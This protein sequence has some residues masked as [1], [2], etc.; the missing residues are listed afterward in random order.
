MIRRNQFLTTVMVLSATSAARDLLRS[1]KPVD[2]KV[3]KL[4]TDGADF[5]DARYAGGFEITI[6]G[7]EHPRQRLEAGDSGVAVHGVLPTSH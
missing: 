6:E 2:A 7:R 5:E 1:V 3:D 4:G